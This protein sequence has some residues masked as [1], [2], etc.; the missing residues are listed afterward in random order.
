MWLQLQ[1]N[2]VLGGQSKVF[3]LAAL[4]LTISEQADERLL[5]CTGDMCLT[6]QNENVMV[7]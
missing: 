6:A 1:F 3:S 2:V 4:V 7:Y 5:Q